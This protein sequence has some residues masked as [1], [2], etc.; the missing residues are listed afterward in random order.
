MVF[1]IKMWIELND[2]INSKYF[3]LTSLIHNKY[4]ECFLITMNFNCIKR[5]PI[6][7]KMRILFIKDY[8]VFKTNIQN[9]YHTYFSAY[10]CGTAVVYVFYIFFVSIWNEYNNF[11]E[12]TLYGIIEN[13]SCSEKCYSIKKN[14]IKRESFLLEVFHSSAIKN[15]KYKNSF[16][17]ERLQKISWL[18]AKSFSLF[19]WFEACNNKEN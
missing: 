16:S 7:S 11:S 4:V 1:R 8:F 12:H 5:F 17:H 18:T 6:K 15:L 10:F 3:I 19:V 13:W 2:S 9:S 14:N